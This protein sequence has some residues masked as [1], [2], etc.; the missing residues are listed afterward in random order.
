M[1]KSGGSLKIVRGFLFTLVNKEFLIFLF[2][3]LLSGIFWLLMTLNETYEMEFRIPIKVVNIPKNVVPTSEDTDTVK[4]TLRDK[5]LVLMGYEYGEALRPLHA[6]FKTYAKSGSSFVI[7]VGDI[8]R[9]LYLQL[10][11]STKISAVKSDRV[12]FFFN[13]GECKKVP[14]VWNGRVVPEEVYFISQVEYYPDSVTVYATREKLDSITYIQTE[15]LNYTGFRDTLT[16]NCRPKTMKGVKVS[17]DRLKIMFIT[18]VLTE[19]SI[20][21]IPIVGINM[22]QG[23]VLRTFPSKVTVSF[24]TG[25]R[26][27]KTL[28]SKDFSVFVD[29]NEIKSHPA[30]KCNL[31]LRGVP[32]GVSRATLNLKNV[33]YLIENEE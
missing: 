11:A 4:V 15:H 29:Y 7:P 25:V 21:N 18:D 22:P 3:L 5:G 10:S 14:V 1:I 27:F 13:Y 24:V 6:N 12:E 28:S 8:Q 23:K 16:V 17:P 32:H 31:H 26:Q 19:E 9:Q 2:F 20:D 33:D 30:D